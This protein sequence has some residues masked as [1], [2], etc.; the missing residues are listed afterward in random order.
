MFDL[1]L[2]FSFEKLFCKSDFKNNF[3]EIFYTKN[4]F[5][6]LSFKNCFDIKLKNLFGKFIFKIYFEN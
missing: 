6:A 4:M 2:V 1:V 3:K 5:G